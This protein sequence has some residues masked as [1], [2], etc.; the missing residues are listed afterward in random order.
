MRFQASSTNVEN[1]E[2]KSFGGV[3]LAKARKR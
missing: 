2:I 3:S 1:I